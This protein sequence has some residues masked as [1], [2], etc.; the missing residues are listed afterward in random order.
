M[1]NGKSEN[2]TRH[3]KRQRYKAKKPRKKMD[4]LLNVL[5]AIVSILIVLNLVSI[6][7]GDDKKQNVKETNQVTESKKNDDSKEVVT[8]KSEDDEPT[9]ND[10]STENMSDENENVYVVSAS[11]QIVQP[12]NDPIVDEVIVNPSW[13]VTPTKQ[14]G[15]H[16]SA[17]E[18]GHIDY[19]EK[20]ETFRNVVGLSEDEV[21]YWSIKNNGNPNSSVA[22]IS[23]NDSNRAY[24]YRIHIEWI[25]NEGWKPIK[26]EKLN[27]LA[28]SY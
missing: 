28:N 5:I 21:I 24:K 15:E 7:T 12:S 17:Y 16:V 13:Q 9:N 3:E 22:V 2:S 11:E 20:K 1:N 19:E 6:F 14:T 8:D 27:Q 25:E 18:E 26:V 4:R 10:Y 23:S